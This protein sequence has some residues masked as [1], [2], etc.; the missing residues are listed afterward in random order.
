MT[1][2][3]GNVTERY[4]YDAYGVPTIFDAAGVELTSSAEKNRFMYTGREWDED[5]SLY[6]Y[7]ARM[8]DP[9]S[10]RF[11]S[12]DPIGYRGGINLYEYVRSRPLVGTDPHGLAWTVPDYFWWYYFG[13]GR[14]VNITS[15]GLFEPWLNDIQGQLDI[16]TNLIKQSL[17]DG[18]S[19]SS[20]SG[21]ISGTKPVRTSAGGGLTNPLTVMGN[22]IVKINYDCYAHMTCEHCS[23]SG[24]APV[25]VQGNCNFSY[26]VRDR[27]ANPW[28]WNG[29]GYERNEQAYQACRSACAR[30]Y[31]ILNI[32]NRDLRSRCMESCEARYPRSEF[33]GA[34]PYDLTASWSNM[35]RWG[36]TLEG[37]Q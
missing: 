24:M 14:E 5:L 20:P 22:S 26:S 16:Q 7:R 19:C 25:K 30:R 2:E 8:Y 28:D 32:W 15:T 23:C 18:L 37:C 13:G 12:R 35:D 4:A 9:Y 36:T 6:Y 33:Y 3:S 1:D 17:T 10:G 34:T 21:R 31:P 27:F 11:C 29:Q